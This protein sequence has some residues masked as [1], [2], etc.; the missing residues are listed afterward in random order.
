VAAGYTRAA[1]AAQNVDTAGYQSAG[2]QIGSASAGLT[3]ALHGLST[4]GYN[5]GGT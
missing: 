2:T 1:R 5:V 3:S 4:L